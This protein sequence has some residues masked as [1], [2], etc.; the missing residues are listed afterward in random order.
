M[1]KVVRVHPLGGP[2][3]L[4][5]EDVDVGAPG[6]GEVRLKVEAIGLNRSEV[7]YRAG[8]YPVEPKL[9]TLIGYEGVG[10]I[11]ALGP[12]VSGFAAGERV[13]VIP[14]FRMGEYGLYAAGELRECVIARP[15]RYVVPVGTPS[16][17]C[18]W[19]SRTARIPCRRASLYSRG[20][21]MVRNPSG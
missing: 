20:Q 19:G 5:I 11:D 8:A 21:S 17:S 12:D 14:N 7:A 1:S 13:C 15:Y 9:P 2:E 18:S 3:E 16:R 4:R 6:P 10:V